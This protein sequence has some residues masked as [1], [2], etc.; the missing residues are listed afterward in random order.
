MTEL[1]ANAEQTYP[2]SPETLYAILAD[3]Q[4]RHQR[5]LPDAY[6]DYAVEAGG[7]GVGTVVRWVLHVGNHRR[8]YAMQVSEPEA[9][10]VLTEQERESSFRTEWRI[11]PEGKGSRVRLRSVWRQRAHGF[12]AFFE[13]MFA[14]RSLAKLHAETLR[15]LATEAAKADAPVP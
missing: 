5:I 13:R 8:P 1:Q 15:R 6:H 7:A 14:P 9:G 3:Y 2:Q 10:R 11:T 12:P 4:G